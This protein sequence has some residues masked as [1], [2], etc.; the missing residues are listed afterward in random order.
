MTERLVTKQVGETFNA[1][2]YLHYICDEFPT[3]TASYAMELMKISMIAE[4]PPKE[5]ASRAC[6]LAEAM[7]EEIR[8]RKWVLDKPYDY[9][10]IGEL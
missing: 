8:R 9:P 1:Q 7:L 2:W 3:K 10:E 4:L 6:D 5:A